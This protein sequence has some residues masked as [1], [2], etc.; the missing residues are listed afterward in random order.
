M[1]QL[2]VRNI[3]DAF[4]AEIDGLDPRSELE[5]ETRHLLRKLFDDRGVLVFRGLDIDSAFQDTICRML[6]GDDHF[7]EVIRRVTYGRPDPKPGNFKPQF[8]TSKGFMA[9]VNQVTGKDYDWFFNIYLYRAGLPKLV[10][11]RVGGLLKLRWET[12]DNLPFPMPVDIRVDTYPDR[13]WSGRVESI[14]QA[15]GAEFSVIPAQNATGNWVK[16]AQRISV[17]IA[18]DAHGDDPSLRAG[19]SAI[20]D[21]DTGYERPAPRWV[22]ALLPSSSAFAKDR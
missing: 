19:M 17:R 7:Y 4:G 11:S 1:A 15:T 6:I 9:T 10:E 14:S 18:V 12:P 13:R 3:S 20:V 21:I 8:G 5:G 22:R 16:V 2:H